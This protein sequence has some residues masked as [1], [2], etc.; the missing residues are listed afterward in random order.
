MLY[1]Y[2]W[3]QC[4]DSRQESNIKAHGMDGWNTSQNVLKFLVTFDNEKRLL[5]KTWIISLINRKTRDYMGKAYTYTTRHG[6]PFRRLP[7]RSWSSLNHYLLICIVVYMCGKLIKYNKNYSSLNYDQYLHYA[8]FFPDLNKIHLT[9]CY[10]TN[11]YDYAHI[12][13]ISSSWKTKY[14]SDVIDINNDSKHKTIHNMP[15]F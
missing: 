13:T 12:L 14:S 1:T 6:F 7:K 9:I 2:V 8:P 15:C 4:Y 3:Q 10:D 5:S 11:C